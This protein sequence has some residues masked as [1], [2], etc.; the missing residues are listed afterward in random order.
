MFFVGW[1]YRLRATLAI[2][3]Y[4]FRFCDSPGRT[5]SYLVSIALAIFG[6]FFRFCDLPDAPT[7]EEVAA[8]AIFGYF[9]RFCDLEGGARRRV[10]LRTCDFRLLLQV[11]R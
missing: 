2:F 11:L 7:E 9:F 6:Y 4:F 5:L 8:L 10:E 1:M 3:G